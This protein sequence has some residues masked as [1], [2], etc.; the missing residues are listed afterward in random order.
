MTVK[1]EPS[2]PEID[3]LVGLSGYSYSAQLIRETHP[4]NGDLPAEKT[5]VSP[6][7]NNLNL[8]AN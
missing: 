1:E 8:I 4:R 5:R 6:G 2:P 3:E 7:V